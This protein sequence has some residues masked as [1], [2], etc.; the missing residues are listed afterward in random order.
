MGGSGFHQN[1]NG[2][3][4]KL[5]DPGSEAGIERGNQ[6][7]FKIF[8]AVSAFSSLR[9]TVVLVSTT[10]FLKCNGRSF[11]DLSSS[12]ITKFSVGLVELNQLWI[13]SFLL[14]ESSTVYKQGY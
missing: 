8:I 10:F 5:G 1:D 7:C 6:A 13:S 14:K 4:K 3:L 2:F 12:M 9:P 11:K